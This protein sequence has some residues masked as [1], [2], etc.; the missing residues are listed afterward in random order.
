MGR[1]GAVQK[2]VA[3]RDMAC[4]CPPKNANMSG[5]FKHDLARTL[6][7]IA[8]GSP[9]WQ[10]L[11][12]GSILTG[13]AGATAPTAPRPPPDFRQLAPL[14][15]V[16]EAARAAGLTL[17]GLAPLEEREKMRPGDASPCW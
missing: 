15:A 12:L 5:D 6:R 2:R 8:P 1:R 17:A 10:V 4:S 13:S 9:W 14:P 3:N 11:I 16:Q 7:P